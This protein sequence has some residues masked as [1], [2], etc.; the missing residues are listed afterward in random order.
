MF[1]TVFMVMPFADA[2]ANSAY[3]Y[4]TKP[5]VESMGYLIRRADEIFSANPVFDDI[6]T[7]I[8]QCAVVIVDISGRNPNCF[9][10]L[11]MAHVLKRNRTI[12]ITHD[13]FSD[14]P[15]DIAHFRILRYENSIQ[16]KTAYEDALRSTLKSITTGLP[17]LYRAEFRL[18]VDLFESQEG[19]HNLYLMMAISRTRIRMKP[20]DSFRVSGHYR[21]EEPVWAHGRADNFLKP[22]AVRTYVELVDNAYTLTDRGQAFVDFLSSE[23]YVV[24]AL[25]KELFTPGHVPF[26][27]AE[28]APVG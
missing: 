4:S 28:G 11:G 23:G 8:E 14:A 7:A 3:R 27:D 26:W 22:F 5:V 16:G 24:D 25:N 17:E 21:G 1:D 13:A 6:V 12:M 15:F 18:V 19:P 10:E 2:V 20:D 9:Y